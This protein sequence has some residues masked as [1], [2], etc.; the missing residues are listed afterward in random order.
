MDLLENDG[1]T[2]SLMVKNLLFPIQPP[3]ISKVH[4]HFE[5][6]LENLRNLQPTGLSQYGST[7]LLVEGQE[8]PR[9]IGLPNVLG[10][11]SPTSPLGG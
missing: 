10:A 2:P 7:A 9:E 3:E 1:N 6:H 5:K 4:C 8:Q 11:G